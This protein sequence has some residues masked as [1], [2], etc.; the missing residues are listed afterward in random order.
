MECGSLFQNDND[1]MPSTKI[2]LQCFTQNTA[3][4]FKRPVCSP[5]LIPVENLWQILKDSIRQR[6]DRS[7]IDFMFI[8]KKEWDKFSKQ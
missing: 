4:V 8:C 6:D 5:V 3:D 1:P 7:I 2:I